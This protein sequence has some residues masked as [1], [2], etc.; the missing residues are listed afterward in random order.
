[1]VGAEGRLVDVVGVHAHLVIPR[2]KVELGEEAS[3]M[4]LVQELIHHRDREFIYGRLG[5]EGA[6]VDAETPRVV[7]L[8][9]QQDWRGERRSAGPNDPLDQH[10]SALAF[11]LVLL[12]LGVAIGPYRDRRG[13][14]QEVDAVVVWA[15][16]REPHGLVEDVVMLQEEVVEQQQ[17]RVS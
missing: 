8:P 3:P 2:A 4:K 12:H 1:M 13:P 7:H 9:D 15:R 6:I 16:R 10:G 17:P 5:V 11:E 14:R